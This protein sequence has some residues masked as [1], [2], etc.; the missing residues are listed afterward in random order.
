MVFMK[1]KYCLL[2]LLLALNVFSSEEEKANVIPFN[3]SI[4]HLDFENGSVNALKDSSFSQ[5]NILSP[6]SPVLTS[7]V[8]GFG[9]KTGESSGALVVENSPNLKMTED[10]TVFFWLKPDNFGQRKKIFSKRKKDSSQ[11]FLTIAED[12]GVLYA[13]CGKGKDF[14]ITPKTSSLEL[15]QWQHLALTLNLKTQLLSLYLNG[16]K[17]QEL[18]C[19]YSLSDSDANLSLG[20][21]FEGTS[22]FFEGTFDDL[23]ILNTALNEK[24]IQNMYLYELNKAFDFPLKELLLKRGLNFY[25]PFDNLSNTTV[26]PFPQNTYKGS[27]LGKGISLVEGKEMGGL[28]FSAPS[29]QIIFPRIPPVLLSSDFSLTLWI[30]PSDMDGIQKLFSFLSPA[31]DPLLVLA[32]DDNRLIASLDPDFKKSRSLKANTKIPENQWSLLSLNYYKDSNEMELF[33]NAEQSEKSQFK[34]TPSLNQVSMQIGGVFENDKNYFKGIIDEVKFHN[35]CLTPNDILQEINGT[36]PSLHKELW[37]WPLDLSKSGLIAYYPLDWSSPLKLLD[38]SSLNNSA[39]LEKSQLSPSF[40]K[41]HSGLGLHFNNTVITLPSTLYFSSLNTFSFC[42]WISPEKVDS[43]NWILYKSI[44]ESQSFLGL[45]IENGKFFIEAGNG[46]E[47]FYNSAITPVLPGSWT[48]ITLSYSELDRQIVLFLNGKKEIEDTLKISLEPSN[49][50]YALGG[51]V[52]SN[53]M[54]IMDEIKFF[55]KVLPPEMTASFMK[56]LQFKFP[57]TFELPVKKEPVSPPAAQ[58]QTKISVQTKSEEIQPVKISPSN[59]SVEKN[60]NITADLLSYYE[61]QIPLPYKLNNILYYKKNHLISY[62]SFETDSLKGMEDELKSAILTEFDENHPP[63]LVPGQIGKGLY[64]QQKEC[65][66]LS[67][68]KLRFPHNFTFQLSIFPLSF[69]KSTSSFLS[70]VNKDKKNMLSFEFLQDTLI[71]TDEENKIHRSSVRLM[72]KIWQS[73][74]FSYNPENSSLY[75]FKNNILINEFKI[76]LNLAQPFNIIFGKASKMS[77]EFIVDEIKIYQ[78]VF[79]ESI[80]GI[81]PPENP[82]ISLSQTQFLDSPPESLGVALYCKNASEYMIS[83]DST[84]IDGRWKPIKNH[85]EIPL[86]RTTGKHEVYC[87][88]KNEQ[89]IESPP[90]KARY[91]INKK[92]NEI[93]FSNPLPKSVIPGKR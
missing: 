93:N 32:L 28:L 84:F 75:V 31:K 78:H 39:V 14:I 4:L 43:R 49:F 66:S 57:F 87:K 46:P 40:I 3:H 89:G 7:G 53:F 24:Q 80:S 44:K 48:H 41:G 45:G 72:E 77:S 65:L 15:N 27:L 74:M 76:Q 47:K 9:L 61:P 33:V 2:Y 85:T 55:K 1:S 25:L 37:Q 18:T 67:D 16:K 23:I 21:D 51:H 60:K 12:N 68:I 29:D 38:I 8:Y 81:L 20:A 82:K 70:L 71:A 5:N 63:L 62:F 86:T 50:T 42:A 59:S 52:N 54:G 56:D 10:L 34:I 35:R 69:S 36:L 30:R 26:Y 91:E 13:A 88:F 17:I 64:I 92:T 22:D 11:D 19:P 90:V 83:H 58:I 79:N 6:V 73:L